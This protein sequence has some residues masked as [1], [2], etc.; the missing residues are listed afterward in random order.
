MERAATNA[1]GPGGGAGQERPEVDGVQGQQQPDNE[2]ENIPRAKKAGFLE[3]FMTKYDINAPTLMMMFKG[4]VPPI[5]AIAMYQ[6]H[7]VSSYYVTVGYL[8]PI[9][10][11]LALPL[12]PRGKFIL[13]LML[14]TLAVCLGAAMSMLMLWSAVKAR[15]NTTPGDVKSVLSLTGAPYNSSQSAVC[16]IWLFF[17]I[18]FANVVRAKLPTFNMPVIIYSIFINVTATYGPWFTS[19][20]EAEYF[21]KQ[22]FTSMLVA[23]ALALGANLLVFP[24]SSRLVVFKE[25]AGALGLLKKTVQLQK[26]YLVRLES[27]DMFAVATRT[28]THPG[29]GKVDDHGRPNLTKE[30]KAAQ[31]LKATIDVLSGLA[32][33]LNADLAFAKR[34]VAWGKL[35]AGDLSDLFKHF[36]DVYVPVMGM[37]TIVD[38]FKRVAE[39]RG[40][41]VE[42]EDEDVIC[43]KDREKRV[44]NQVMKQMHEPFEI[45]SEA[46]CQGLDH[47]GILLELL[48]RPAEKRD[49]VE[50]GAGNIKSGDGGF[51]AVVGEKINQFNSRKGELLRAWLQERTLANEEEMASMEPKHSAERRERQQAQLHIVLYMENLMCSA[52]RAVQQ[53]IEFAEEK[54]ADGTMSKS[55]LIVPTP[56]RLRKWIF[57]V[58]SSED[59]SADQAPDL[60]ESRANIV[61]FGDGYNRKRDP[62]HL[63]PTNAWERFGYRLRNISGFLGSEESAFGFR[64]ACATM[65]IGIVAF[66]ENTQHFFMEQRLLWA[67][68]IITIG[69][70]MTSGQSFFGF[71]MRVG[72]TV[73]AMATSLVIWYIVNEHRAGVIVFLWIFIFVEFYFFLK[74]M[75]FI[76]AVVVT[77]VTQVLIIG[78]ELQVLTIG[79]QLAE[80]TGQPYYRIYLLAPYRLA[81]IAG[82]SL[83][84]FFWTI[85][86]KPMTDRTWL[87]RDLSATLYLMANYFGVINSTLAAS[88]DKTVGDINTSHTPAHQLHKA[89]RKIFGKV[90]LLVPS[91]AQHSEWQKWEPTIGGKFPREAYDDIILRSTRIMKY[92]TLVSYTLTHPNGGPPPPQAPADEKSSPPSYDGGQENDEKGPGSS[93]GQRETSRC[94]FNAKAPVSPD[95]TKALHEALHALKPTHNAILS[96]LTLLS[97]S[98]LSGQSLPPFVPLPRPYE[99]TRR[100]RNTRLRKNKKH[101]SASS[102][103]FSS[104]SNLITDQAP[105]VELVSTNKTGDKDDDDEEVELGVEDERPAPGKERPPSSAHLILDPEL[106]EQP[107]YAEFTVLQVCTTLVCDD[108]EGLV[109]TVSGLVGVVDFSIR[110]EGSGST[111]G[112]SGGKGKV[113]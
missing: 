71:I 79:A 4:S 67:L 37:T 77:I 10:S 51:G 76:P 102:S 48:P 30:E 8:I 75:R 56:S 19:V 7:E 50:A 55:R 60:V 53:L 17:N 58:L 82:G 42:E 36:R 47:A 45:L 1:P 27:D 46:I 12:L 106:I 104:T 112:S 96:T 57:S 103:A 90:M 88:V 62:E 21:V 108:L 64:V 70:T 20:K 2:E 24:I 16:A 109:K 73:F 89:G 92:L 99:A 69:M 105:V 93:D 28:D 110:V 85:F 15:E 97:N 43:A 101:E 31:A 66:L 107:G 95:W 91:M 65:T 84:A 72:G 23:L 38:I 98:L 44:W 87:R 6:S 49:D 3:R 29:F 9:I 94:P 41:D 22:L 78:Y 40:W 54:V 74:Y 81:C 100:L 34:D 35:D 86:P 32:G 5:V 113:D 18:W 61:Y 25:F 52:G 39:H 33:K 13:S 11:V 111:L 26:A 59:Q 14:N 80:A 68:I 63:E 83:I